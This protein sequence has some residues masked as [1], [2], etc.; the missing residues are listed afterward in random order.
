MGHDVVVAPLMKIRPRHDVSIPELAYQ[1]IAVTSANGIRALRRG[2]GLTSFRT[3][4]V[5]P[6][7]LTG[8]ECCGLHGGGPWR[9]RQR[10]GRLYP[11]RLDPLGRSD[12]LSLRRGN[13]GRSRGAAQRPR[14]LIATAPFFMMPCRPADASA[15]RRRVIRGEIDAVLLYSPRTARIW[16]GLVEAAA[17][18]RHAAT[19]QEFLPVTQCCRSPARG[20]GSSRR[21]HRHER[22]CDAG[23][24]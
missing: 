2:H 14:A 6:Q 11:R 5:G 1:A 16:R 20:Y 4:T 10:P 3:L 12:P 22:G 7:S 9:R 13:G 23:P 18:R 24:A 19:S 21:E 15:R 8:G 17:S